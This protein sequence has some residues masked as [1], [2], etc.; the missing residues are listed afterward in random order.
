LVRASSFPSHDP[1][2]ARAE[3]QRFGFAAHLDA[4]LAGRFVSSDD[5]AW[6]IGIIIGTYNFPATLILGAVPRFKFHYA[7]PKKVHARFASVAS[8]VG[9]ATTVST[10]PALNT[11]AEPNEKV[12]VVADGAKTIAPTLMPFR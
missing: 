3:A 9:G 6:D 12:A 2:P 4:A 10:S 5:L 7:V 11:V 1:D 8:A